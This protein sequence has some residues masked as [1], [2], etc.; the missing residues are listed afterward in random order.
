MA[1][2]AAATAQPED[3]DATGTPSCTELSRASQ[4]TRPENKNKGHTKKK[5][6]AQTETHSCFH[7]QSASICTGSVVHSLAGITS[8]IARDHFRSG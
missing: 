1:T 8:I 4:E 3:E 5:G 6:A 7:C 2:R